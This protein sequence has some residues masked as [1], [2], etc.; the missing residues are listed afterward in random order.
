MAP[1]VAVVVAVPAAL[2]A[3]QALGQEPDVEVVAARHEPVLVAAVVLRVVPDPD[4]I[5]QLP[6]RA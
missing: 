1:D 6:A 5:R 2:H 4:R 3:A